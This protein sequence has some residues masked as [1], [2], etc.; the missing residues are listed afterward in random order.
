MCNKDNW[1][2]REHHTALA[3]P[4]SGQLIWVASWFLQ[5]ASSVSSENKGK[6][7]LEE[8]E[9]EG[10]TEEH[11]NGVDNC[12]GMANQKGHSMHIMDPLW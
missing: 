5:A 11:G 8:K 2:S 7:G 4:D 10:R 3:N 6:P 9:Q 12:S 1:F